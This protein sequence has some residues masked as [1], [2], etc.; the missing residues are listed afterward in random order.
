MKDRPI[1][2]IA[3]ILTLLV[4]L[5]IVFLVFREVGSQRLPSQ[6]LRIFF[7]LILIGFI[8]SKKS[9]GALLLLA[10]FHIFTGL[11]HF[12]SLEKSGLVGE[13]LMI[14]HIVIG[15]IIYFHDW[16]EDKLKIKR[17]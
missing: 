3:I 16:F 2:T 14:Y 15:I 10:G 11:M 13:I 6:L 7:E 4:E 1:L 17:A 12:G 5:I 8:V 9:N